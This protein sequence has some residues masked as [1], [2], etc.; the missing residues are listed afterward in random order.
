MGV[1]SNGEYGIPKGIVFGFPVTTVNGEYK[2]VEGLEIDAFSQERI[3]ITL[4][5]LQGE[6]DGVK[7]LL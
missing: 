5:E 4:A 6:A 2:I 1:P 3:N 7:H